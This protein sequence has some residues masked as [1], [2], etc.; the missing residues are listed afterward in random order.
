MLILNFWTS[1]PKIFYNSKFSLSHT[2]FNLKAGD[3]VF[4]DYD[5]GSND[6]MLMNYGFLID[7]NPYST[8]EINI[9]EL[10]Q[11]FYTI[12]R[13]RGITLIDFEL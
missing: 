3:Q 12:F 6:Y 8:I 9:K 4:I 13:N 7:R 10:N 11:A 1:P 2:S 5:Q